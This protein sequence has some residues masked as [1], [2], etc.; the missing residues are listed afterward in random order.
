MLTKNGWRT[1]HWLALML[2]LDKA[3]VSL[4]DD[5]TEGGDA[6]LFI[7]MKSKTATAYSHNLT[8]EGESDAAS[9]RLSG[10]EWD[11]DVRGYVFGDD[12]GVVAHV[13]DDSFLLIGV[14]V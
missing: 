9:F 10:E 5:D 13:D 7:L 6:L 8:G 11:K 14:G 4:R 2:T 1:Y 12:T 3:I